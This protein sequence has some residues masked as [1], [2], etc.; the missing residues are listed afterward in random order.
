MKMGAEVA[1]PYCGIL[2]RVDIEITGSMGC[3]KCRNCG[4]RF[5][6]EITITVTAIGLKIEGE[7]K[8]EKKHGC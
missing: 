6:T 3:T 8:K 2:N 7:E 1:C 5:V 4:R